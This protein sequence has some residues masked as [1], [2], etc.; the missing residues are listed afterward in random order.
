MQQHCVCPIPGRPYLRSLPRPAQ[1]GAELS[2]C[3]DGDLATGYHSDW[4]LNA[5]PDTVDFYFN[6]VNNINKIEYVPRSSGLNG[7]WRTVALWAR[8]TNGPFVKVADLNWANDNTTKIVNVAANGIDTP[9]CVRFVVSQATGNFSSC[10][11]MI[12]WSSTPTVIPVDCSNP[13][14]GLASLLDKKLTANNA[15]VSPAAN[16]AGE[17]IDKTLDNDKSTLYHS[18]WAGGGFRSR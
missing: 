3:Y 15:S 11:E 7:V 13:T 4:N 18:S 8:K 2:K 12:F 16:S 10:N 6:G 9:A 14:S 1:P 5:I 17:G